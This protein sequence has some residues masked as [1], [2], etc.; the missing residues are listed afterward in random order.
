MGQPP[1]K[2]ARPGT[3]T[4]VDVATGELIP[5][6]VP[7]KVRWWPREEEYVSVMQH[8]AQTLASADL[9]RAAYRV[10]YHLLACLDWENWI[11]VSQ[12]EVARELKMQPSHVSTAFRELERTGWLL[13]GPKVGSSFTWKLNPESV[14]KGKPGK[15]AQALKELARERWGVDDPA[16][17]TADSAA[18]DGD[19]DGRPGQGSLLD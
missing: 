3:R 16:P 9:S 7:R 6:L 12:S 15:R 18:G 11:R 2:P 8:A 4:F 10:S 13:R 19:G 1:A 5:M 17:T 14:W